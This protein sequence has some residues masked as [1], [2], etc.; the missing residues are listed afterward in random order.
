MIPIGERAC[1]RS[2][3]N[4]IVPILGCPILIS[5]NAMLVIGKATVRKV[6]NDCKVSLMTDNRPLKVQIKHFDA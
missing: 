6:S 1:S 2:T 3:H 4:V 5:N